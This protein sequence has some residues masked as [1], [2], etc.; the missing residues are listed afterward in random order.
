ME[1]CKCGC[2][3]LVKGNRKFVNKEHQSE[4]MNAGGARELNALLPHEV[5]VKAGEKMGRIAADS[6]RLLESAQKGGAKS[7]EIAAKVRAKQQDQGN[8]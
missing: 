3:E 8:A 1:V 4:W 2:G 7:R 6:G 5:R